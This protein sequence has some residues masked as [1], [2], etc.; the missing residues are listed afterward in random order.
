[1]EERVVEEIAV[2]EVIHCEA[3]S[4]LYMQREERPRMDPL[5][6]RIDKKLE[7]L[8]NFQILTKYI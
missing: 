3:K 5:S 2:Q 4:P 1:M 6:A 7:K 8:A